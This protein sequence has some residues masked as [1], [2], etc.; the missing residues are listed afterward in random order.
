M[1]EKMGQEKE[2][3]K[4]SNCLETRRSPKKRNAGRIRIQGE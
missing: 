2:S 4:T 1:D 3:S